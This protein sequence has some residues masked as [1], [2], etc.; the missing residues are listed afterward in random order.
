MSRVPKKRI[1]NNE[2]QANPV[3]DKMVVSQGEKMGLREHT[4]RAK[5]AIDFS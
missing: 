1:E 5:R 3:S 2:D 4:R